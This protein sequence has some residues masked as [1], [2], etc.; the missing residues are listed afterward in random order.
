MKVTALLL[1]ALALS[2]SAVAEERWG[3]PAPKEDRVD[4]TTLPECWQR[5]AIQANGLVKPWDLNTISKKDFCED[6]RFIILYWWKFSF[7]K[8]V[9]DDCPEK[10]A[11]STEGRRWYK[12]M[13]A[14]FGI[15][16]VH[17]VR[18]SH[19]PPTSDLY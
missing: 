12:H 8:C 11:R 6:Q 2:S 1:T 5:C 13:C 19:E 7:M 4:I 15:T 18:G 3:A 10:A 17:G 14:P 9:E 16:S